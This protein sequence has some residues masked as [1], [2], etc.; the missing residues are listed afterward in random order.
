MT[1]IWT[2]SAVVLFGLLMSVCLYCYY[3]FHRW[4]LCS[5]TDVEYLWYV[6]VS[7]RQDV[8]SLKQFGQFTSITSSTRRHPWCW[9]TYF[10]WTTA[11]EK[12]KCLSEGTSHSSIDDQASSWIHLLSIQRQ[13]HYPQSTQTL[14]PKLQVTQIW[15]EGETQDFRERAK[16][17]C[18]PL[19]APWKIKNFRKFNTSSLW[20]STLKI[21]NLWGGMDG[22]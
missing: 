14:F 17:L 11:W 15:S 20:G 3:G 21:Q 8:F 1:W 12:N 7:V 19:W 6:S 22:N 2:W 5:E 9:L 13:F 18:E 4:L 16:G 10:G